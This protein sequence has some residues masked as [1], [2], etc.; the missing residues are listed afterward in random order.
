MLVQS[1]DK[2][3]R[4]G[5]FDPRS[6]KLVE[7]DR[8]Q[9]SPELLASPLAGHF[10][11]LAGKQVVFFRF[12]DRLR[13]SIEGE[14][15][16]LTDGLEFEWESAGESSLLRLRNGDLVACEVK[17]E[18]GPKTGPPLKD[19]PT[20]FVEM[21]DWDFGLFIHNVLGNPDRAAG[22]YPSSTD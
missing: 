13:L 21:E 10:T 19:D 8:E 11:M 14:V 16:D 1:N 22:I 17:Y 20:P 6:A 2:F 15:W 12:E 7:F 5:D 4:V 3:N 18:P 9:A